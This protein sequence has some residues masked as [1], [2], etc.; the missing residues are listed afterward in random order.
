MKQ[1]AAV[2][3]AGLGGLAAACL[4]SAKGYRVTVFEKNDS[5]GGKMQEFNKAGYRFDTG[6]SLLT[7]SFI[8]ERLFRECGSHMPGYLTLT[9]PE[10]LCRY[11]YPDDTRFDSYS[12]P[13]K[14][15]KEIRRF[16]PEDADAYGQFLKKAE[17]L[18]ERTSEAFLFNPLFSFSDLKHLNFSDFLKI[19]AFSTVSESV[20]QQF[21]SPYL[22]QFFKRF[23]TYTGSSPYQAPATLN[24]IPHT[25]LNM[26]GFYVKGGIYTIAKSLQKL[27]EENGTDFRFNCRVDGILIN[28][29]MI[30]GIRL[31]NGESIK[32]DYCFAN[33]DAT[34]TLLNLM[35]EGL[36]PEKR[37]AR[38]ASLEPSG[39]GFVL[40]LGCSRQWEQLR[41]HNIFFSPDYEQEFDDIFK[42][43][44]LPENPT[45]YIANTSFSDP[46][47]APAGSSNLFVL[48]NAPY[49]QPSGLTD[50]DVDTCYADFIIDELEKRGLTGLRGSIEVQKILTPA[51]FLNN[52]GSNRGSIYGTSSNS[53]LSAFMRPRNKLRGFKNLYQVGGSTH[54]G[55][56]IPLVIQS[57][58]NAVQLLQRN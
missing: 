1:R 15:V 35:P 48:V 58:F 53:R 2:I 6:P 18:Y 50:K 14:T 12:D 21:K 51:D 13:D 49:I 5:A 8:L 27:A 52:Y 10:T 55:G 26:G 33:S 38:Q 44:K 7:M 46:G 29:K 45:V 4:L 24:V 19:D 28:K 9:E 23:T 3:G 22:R 36:L 16:A 41:H 57:A 30:T 32:T 54:P 20:D 40:L 34:D 43:K 17:K 42:K 37:K 31:Q 25:E 56:G 39:S 47:H 11:F